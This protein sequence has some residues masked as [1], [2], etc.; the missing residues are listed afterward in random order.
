MVR[1]CINSELNDS[2]LRP[3][4]SDS[5]LVYDAAT[6]SA[7]LIPGFGGNGIQKF[8]GILLNPATGLLHLNPWQ[9]NHSH[10]PVIDPA[11]LADFNGEWIDCLR[12]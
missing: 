4:S 6:L 11:R 9:V 7:S 10:S 8:S 1:R 5:L 12:S 3:A 2:V